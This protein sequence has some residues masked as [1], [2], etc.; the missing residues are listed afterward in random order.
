MQK[1]GNSLLKKKYSGS[2]FLCRREADGL[3]INM[4]QDTRTL[5]IIFFNHDLLHVLNFDGIQIMDALMV[6]F[7][8]SS[9]FVCPLLPSPYLPY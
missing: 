4:L 3:A 5:S 6:L 2:I 7:S 1:E 8:Y 9:S